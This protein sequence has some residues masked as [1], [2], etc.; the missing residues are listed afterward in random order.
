MYYLKLLDID[1]EIRIENEINTE[2]KSGVSEFNQQI[3]QFE[4]LIETETR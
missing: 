4:N 2:A 3:G 1:N